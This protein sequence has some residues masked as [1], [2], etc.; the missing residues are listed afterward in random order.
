MQPLD[1]FERAY[2]TAVARLNTWVDAQKDVANVEREQTPTFWRARITP[3][4]YNAMPIELIMHRSQRCD[5]SLGDETYENQPVG[6]PAR[7]QRILEAVADGCATVFH[8]HSSATNT[9]TKVESLVALADGTTWHGQR[10]IH[11]ARPE[12]TERE[13]RSALPWRRVT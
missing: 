12:N 4:A 7:W 13:T 3:A 2:D 11:A 5:F 1:S 9:L 8:W 10:I 6:D